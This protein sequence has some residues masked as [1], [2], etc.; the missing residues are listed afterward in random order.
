M[1]EL[2]FGRRKLIG[3][4]ALAA[5]ALSLGAC[6]TTEQKTS[7]GGQG[8]A[9]AK[10]GMNLLLWTPSPSEEHFALLE[11]LHKW[12][13][14]GA[15]FPMFDASPDPKWARLR[16]H[17][18]GIGLERTVSTSV[19]D[20]VNPVSEDT[21]IRRAACE[22]L[23]RLADRTHELGAK[24]I[25]GPLY[26]PVGRLV[27]RG[28][29]E[30]EFG[31]CAEVIREASDYAADAGIC[32][33]HEPLNRF[34]TYMFNSQSDGCK[35][36]D[37]VDRPNFGLHYDTFHANIEEKNSASAIRH[38]G[39][40]IHHVH[41]SESDRSTPGTGQ[42]HWNENFAALKDI[43]YDRWL[44]IEAFGRALPE[45]AAATCIWRKM[46]ES[47]EQLVRDGLKFVKRKWNA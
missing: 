41:L 30:T 23:K 11:N 25:C 33:S 39:K 31:Y 6:Q 37:A 34:E 29:T 12:G 5:G 14:D 3:G 8:S 35:L 7:A 15:E 32:F 1:T 42:V 18:N 46:Y 17:C 38:A 2:K 24:M 22:N 20:E 10:F 47:E 45:I 9:K 28:R 19:Q 16:Q 40:R 13:Y 21:S 4:S 27:G 44:V 43:G 36:V 26:S